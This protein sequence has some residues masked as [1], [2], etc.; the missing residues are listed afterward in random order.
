MIYQHLN[1]D[2]LESHLARHTNPDVQK[3]IVSD[4]VFSTNGTKADIN[5]LVH[6]KQR[7]NAILIIDASHSLGLNLF[8]YHADID[9]VTSSLSKAWGAHG[10]L[11]L[12]SKDIKDLIINKGRSLIYSSSLPSYHL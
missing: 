1:Y 10:G 2:D 9:I 4:S 12:S 7:Y 6:L 11:I 8:E 5:R 3:V